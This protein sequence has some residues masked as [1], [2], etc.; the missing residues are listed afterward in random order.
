MLGCS[1]LF[2]PMHLSSF[3][4]GNRHALFTWHVAGI[5]ESILIHGPALQGG[6]SLPAEYVKGF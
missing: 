4:M 2:L 3:L 1:S 6:F 5:R